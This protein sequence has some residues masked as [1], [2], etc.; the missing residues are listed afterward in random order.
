MSSKRL[1]ESMNMYNY[2]NQWCAQ[3]LKRP[4]AKIKKGHTL[5][6]ALG[7]VCIM[8]RTVNKADI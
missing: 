1:V 3:T 5:L 4:G 8:A 2:M 7:C 6:W